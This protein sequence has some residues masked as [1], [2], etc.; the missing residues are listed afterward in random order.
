MLEPPLAWRTCGRSS[1]VVKVLDRGWLVTS[2]S[3]AALKIHRVGKR[4]TLSLSRAQTSSHCYGV[5]VKRGGARSG[6]SIIT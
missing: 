6:V 1:Q 4:C 3:P 5:V 2:S